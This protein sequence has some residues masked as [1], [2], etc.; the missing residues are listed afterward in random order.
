MTLGMIQNPHDVMR[1]RMK[2]KES[3]FS[4]DERMGDEIGD[5]HMEIEG[6]IGQDRRDWTKFGVFYVEV[7]GIGKVRRSRRVDGKGTLGPRGDG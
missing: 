5:D 1:G 2:G 7:H 4:I 6:E 3:V